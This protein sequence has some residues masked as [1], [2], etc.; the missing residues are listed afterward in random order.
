[1]CDW[2]SPTPHPALQY[3][4]VRDVVSSLRR[5]R[6]HE[7]Q[8]THP[9]LLVLNSFGPH[10]MHVKLMATMFQNLF[11]SIN[12]HQVGR[13]WRGG[14]CGCTG[15][16]VAGTTHALGWMAQSSLLSTRA[17]S[18]NSSSQR[19]ISCVCLEARGSP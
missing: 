6:M 16:Q 17:E 2:W 11:P 12:V 10:G 3:T 13:A 9:P 15:G 14:R 4:L 7:Q 8:F 5:H 19:Q 1:M 18:S